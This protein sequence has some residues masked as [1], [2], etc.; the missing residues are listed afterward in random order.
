M[1]PD[2]TRTCHR[3]CR[4]CCLRNR[5]MCPV[6]LGRACIRRNRL[7]TAW[8]W[9]CTSAVQ[10]T[11]VAPASPFPL[12]PQEEDRLKKAVNAVP[13]PAELNAMIARSPEEEAQFAA[14][15]AQPEL[16]VT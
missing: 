15:D 2:R 7:D 10:V 11:G 14:M 12:P 9:P 8:I 16:C 13:S 3:R 1:S 6:A 5:T 4:M